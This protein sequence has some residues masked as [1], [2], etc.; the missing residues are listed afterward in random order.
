MESALYQPLPDGL[1]LIETLRYDPAHG[2]VRGLRHLQRM[3]RTASL[4]GLSFD[5]MEAAAHL[6]GVIGDGPIRLRLTFAPG[7]GVRLETFP[8]PQAA[9]EWRVAISPETLQ[10][11]DPWLQIKTSQ[12]ALY[13]RARATLPD[14]V[15]EWLFLNERSELAEGTITNL[16]LERDGVLLTPP[17][18][19]G[20]LPGVLREELLETGRAKEHVLTSRD[21]QEGPL[22]VGNSLRGLIPARLVQA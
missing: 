8:L 10:S 19:S 18:A 21:I 4:L 6:D 3:E 9:K 11:D 1:T 13:D 2:P 7:Q 16:F 22:F 5:K 17:L 15:D 20:C 14:G 12:R